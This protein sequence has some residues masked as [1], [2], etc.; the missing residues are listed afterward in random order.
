MALNLSINCSLN[1]PSTVNYHPARGEF[2]DFA[3]Q[4]FFGGSAR[5]SIYTSVAEARQL[6]E[7]ILDVLPAPV[8]VQ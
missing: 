8:E 5:N 4:I 6:A 1:E 3:V 7:A 2:D